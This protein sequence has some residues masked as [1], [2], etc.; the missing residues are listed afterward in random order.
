LIIGIEPARIFNGK[1]NEEIN[2]VKKE[3]C[4]QIAVVE[5]AYLLCIRAKESAAVE[6]KAVVRL[7]LVFTFVACKYFFCLAHHTISS[8]SF[9]R[10]SL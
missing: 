9:T 2:H 6:A 7:Y 4:L 3:C 8:S 5:N 10:S 1:A